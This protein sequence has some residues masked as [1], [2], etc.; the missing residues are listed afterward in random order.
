MALSLVQNTI[1]QDELLAV[2]ADAEGLSSLL[3]FLNTGEM[4]ELE[5]KLRESEH[6]C[7]VVRRA[8]RCRA[9]LLSTW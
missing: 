7:V 1:S 3:S 4:G 2:A 6:G 5:R 9:L 8:L